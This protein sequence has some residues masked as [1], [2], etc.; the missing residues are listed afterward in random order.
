MQ[1][2]FEPLS[3]SHF[4]LIHCWFNRP[5][6]QAFY[7]LRP[8]T[9]EEV[10]QKLTPYLKG[11]IEGFVIY[12]EKRP[13]GYIQ[14]C[15]IQ[16]YPWEGQEL[17]DEIAQE[18]AGFDLFIGEEEYLGKGVGSQIVD[19]FLTTHIWP[20]YRYC[21]VDPDLR[22]GASIRLFEKCGFRKHKQIRHQNP[23]G[24]QVDLLLY[25]K[26]RSD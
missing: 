21:L 11:K 5:H 18:A 7:S 1:I 25:L 8:W 3:E 24:E 16:D 26:R 14:S 15:P 12:L 10:R 13:I 9:L 2:Q 19:S 22:N 23:L 20:R 6:V 17:P 4:E